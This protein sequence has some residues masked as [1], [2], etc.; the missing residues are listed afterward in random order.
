MA[1]IT[2]LTFFLIFILICASAPGEEKPWR[3]IRSA[4]FRIITDGSEKDGRH[5]ARAFEQ[6]RAVF[7]TQFP[8]YRLDYDAPLIILAPR[9]EAAT[10]K[11]VPE[12]WQ[13][14]GP[15]PAGIFFP[16]WEQ[17]YALVRLDTIGSNTGSKDEFAVV[18]HE[19]VHSLLHLNVHW[20]PTWLDEGLAQFYA[21]TRF[22]GKNTYIGAPPRD[23][24]ALIMIQSWPAQ[25]LKK[26]L[27]QK[28]S[29]TKS[30]EDTELYYEQSWALTHFLTMGPGMEGGERLK[31][32]FNATQ[33]GVEQIKAF[34]DTFGPLAQVQKNF[35]QYVHL[36]GFKAGVIA[37][38]SQIDDKD[39]LSRSMSLAE[40]E[41]E[42]SSFYAT[43]QQWKSARALGESALRNDPKLA[44]A[45]QTMGFVSVHEGKDE[46]AA[47]ELSEAVRLDP[48]LYRAQFAKTMLS[49][50]PHATA[51]D[52]RQAYRME[53]LKTVEG[54]PQFAPAYIEL[55]K[56]YIAQGD[57]N[58]ALRMAL[59]A[60]KLEPWRA[61][62]HL[63]TGQILLR[64]DRPAEAASYATY[65][66]NR[67]SSPDREEAMELWNLVPAAK[68]PAESP[69]PITAKAGVS[70]AEGIVKSVAC[71]EHN[72]MTL[73]LDQG[74]QPLTFRIPEN[75]GG[76]FSDTLWFGEDHYT[77]C[78]H[79]TGLR[80]V[81]QYKPAADKSYTGDAV[82]L[83]FRD[84]LPAAAASVTK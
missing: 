40:T 75:S 35:E 24:W 37:N 65:V 34:Q 17:Q 44:L 14:S 6:L 51:S 72:N 42:I 1:A 68:R 50:L 23:R 18:Y 28:G 39:L 29:I 31:K 53:L 74:G 80:A 76:G 56:L 20:L 83:A 32:F 61:G 7:A 4:H 30:E 78:Y 10:K 79:T 70:D 48:K 36:F 64:L 73:T 81:V 45:H 9:D 2:R 8:G 77:P 21:F 59:K 52:D 25:P 55:A 16:A 19:Y 84:D 41:A 57:P 46:D 49:A 66:A 82:F 63:L 60:E 38:P 69:T 47:R 22:E 13:H 58:Q 12:F 3:E 43:T 27:D 15:K 33:E 26:F 5:V 71:G 11:L 62:Y 54:N 67:W